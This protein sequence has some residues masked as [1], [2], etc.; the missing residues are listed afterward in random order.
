M[1]KVIAPGQ[2][3]GILGG[4]Q[5]GRMAAQAASDMG[6]KVHIFAPEKDSPAFEVSAYHTIAAYEDETALSHFAAQ[7]DVI[8]CE[9]ENVPST[10]A[11]YLNERALVRPRPKIFAICQ[12]RIAEKSFLRSIEVPVT[13]F[14]EVAD[15]S[16]L[17]EAVRTIGYPSILKST[18]LGYDGKGQARIQSEADLP[19]AWE[20]MGGSHAILEAFVDF[21]K[22]ISVIVA[23]NADG[24]IALYEPVENQHRNH[25]LDTTLVPARISPSLFDRAEF[26]ARHIAQELQL[27]G[28]LAVEMFVTAKQE[29]L[30][31]ELAPR[32]HNSGHW[33]MDAAL[34]GQFEQFIR[35][36]CNLPLGATER[37]CDAVMKNLLGDDIHAW[38]SHLADPKVK[39]H[40]YGKT[41]PRPGR[42]MGHIT[43]LIPRF[44]SG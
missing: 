23:R 29:I 25:I 34:T 7:V 39:L 37:T 15:S 43:R 24:A 1:K 38:K 12:E 11:L 2:I 31:N 30:V 32:P 13:N 41:E 20:K 3:I 33:S 6:Y 22:E 35:A 4:G 40:L 14:V 27:E 42:K 18:R 19:S 21:D 9:F 28:M 44:P 5:L 36:V 17:K 16:T 10:T 26:T 8:T